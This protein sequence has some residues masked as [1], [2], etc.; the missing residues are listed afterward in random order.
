VR[1]KLLIE[2]AADL[3]VSSLFHE[4]IE[5]KTEAATY[6]RNQTIF[7]FY[8]SAVSDFIMICTVGL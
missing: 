8:Q 7:F 1:R 2:E 5:H 3:H 6:T 4:G